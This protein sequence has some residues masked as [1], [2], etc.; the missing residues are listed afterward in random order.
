MITSLRSFSALAATALAVAACGGDG[1]R[2][3]DVPAPNA[4]PALSAIADQTINQDTSTPAISF[5]VTD[6]RTAA[7][8]LTV[9]ASSS[10]T[11]LVPADGIVLVGGGATRTVT[12]T[13]TEAAV[14]SATVTLTV[15]DA[16]GLSATR[17]FRVTVNAV[18][19]AFTQYAIDT[20]GA[21]E[22]SDVRS[23]TGFTLDNDSE[24]LPDAFD[25]LLQ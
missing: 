2:A 19:V 7:A 23:L 22:S 17:T 14:G 11:N 15:T 5:G 20:F 12:I 18:R 6:D 1:S 8:D 25:Q 16:A 3:G 24:D 21:D 13:P 10:D 9:T 4:P